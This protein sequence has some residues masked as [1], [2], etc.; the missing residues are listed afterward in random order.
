MHLNLILHTHY[1]RENWVTTNSMADE[2]NRDTKEK[3]IED[4]NSLGGVKPIQ[5]QRGKARIVVGFVL[6]AVVFFLFGVLIGYLVKQ[7]KSKSCSRESTDGVEETSG[8]KKFHDMFKETISTE[9]LES[10]MR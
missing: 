8:F 3:F 6:I 7:P 2:F 5:P 9:K 10:L 4:T 1:Y